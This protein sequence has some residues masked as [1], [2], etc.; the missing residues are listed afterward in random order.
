[1]RLATPTTV[2]KL[3]EAPH[4]KAK[5]EVE[6]AST[7]WRQR[8]GTRQQSARKRRAGRVS[9]P[10]V[11]VPTTGDGSQGTH[12]CPDE[13]ATRVAPRVPGRVRATLRGRRHDPGESR[14][15]EIRTSG[16]PSGD[17]KRSGCK[18][19]CAGPP[20]RQSS[21]LPRGQETVEGA[22]SA[23]CPEPC[24]SESPKN[25]DH[26]NQLRSNCKRL[27]RMRASGLRPSRCAGVLARN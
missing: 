7:S 15:R 5:E 22:A 26:T 1:M 17:W 20:P 6:H 12:R 23:V 25:R 3:R 14:M 8:R 9:A 27:M 4:V 24:P 21:T 16:S 19:G 10:L 2:E 18:S 11:V 13:R